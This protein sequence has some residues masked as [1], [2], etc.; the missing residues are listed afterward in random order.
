V[1]KAQEAAMKICKEGATVQELSQAT[2]VVINQGLK[3]LGVS[4]TDKDITDVVITSA[5]TFTT[6]GRTMC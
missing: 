4:K 6:M 1:L 3:D 5:S 2:R